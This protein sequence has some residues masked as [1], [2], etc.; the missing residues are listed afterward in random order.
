MNTLLAVGGQPSVVLV[1]VF[2]ILLVLWAI[3]HFSIRD[4]P[5]WISGSGIV[6]V[7]LLGILGW[8]ALGNPL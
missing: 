8:A 6:I 5:N 3:G 2:W 4:N 1:V 7:I